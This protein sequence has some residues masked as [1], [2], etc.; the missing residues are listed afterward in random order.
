MWQ[1]GMQQELGGELKPVEKKWERER[2]GRA[3][4][5]NEAVKSAKVRKGEALFLSKRSNR[6]LCK[7]HNGLNIGS[8]SPCPKETRTHTHNPTQLALP[9]VL[10]QTTGWG[11]ACRV[12]S[13]N[14]CF[15]LK[16]RA[17]SWAAG[18]L[19]TLLP[20]VP[21]SFTFSV[22]LHCTGSE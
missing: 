13:P 16:K 12:M 11:N 17:I 15:K 3:K 21:V 22:P 9:S 14:S 6:E 5:G 20:S 18:S 2:N 8:H 10:N 4:G 19:C 7:H 1:R